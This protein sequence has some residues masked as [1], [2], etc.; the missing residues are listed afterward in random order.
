MPSYYFRNTGNTATNLASNWS[1]TDG[2]GATGLVPTSL[3]D[4]YFTSNSGNCIPSTGFVCKILIF[5]GVGAG[6]YSNIF[7]ITNAITVSGNVTLSSTMTITGTQYITINATATLT[8]NGKTWTGGFG[9]TNPITVTLA[10]NWVI[11]GNINITTGAIVINGNQITLNGGMTCGGSPAPTLSGTT[12][13]VFG[14]GTFSGAG[15]NG[16]SN[17]IT[18]NSAGSVSVGTSGS[19]FILNGGTFTY[20][21]GTI[22]QAY[23]TLNGAAFTFNTS[24]MNFNAITTGGFTSPSTITLASIWNVTS[25][26][27]GFSSASNQNL[28]FAGTAGF[29]IGTLISNQANKTITLVSGVTYNINT[30]ITSLFGTSANHNKIISS[31]GGIKSIL[32]LK[33]G[34]TQDLSFVDFTDI[35]GLTNGQKTICTYKGV[36]TNTSGIRLLPTDV[37]TIAY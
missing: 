21:A 24:G 37:Q 1:L 10:D 4:A 30:S 27:V 15:G 8:S 18:I 14:N 35:D 20:T 36:L 16:V 34:A 12:T 13:L 32:T 5:S 3:D 7:T 33:Q 6:N 9:L 28:T 26:T 25:Y 22:T 31:I 23:L 29:N 11:T 19:P 2:G 17:N